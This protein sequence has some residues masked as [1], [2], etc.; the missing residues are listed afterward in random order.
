MAFPFLIL[1]LLFI[2]L[3]FPVVLPLF[4]IEVPELLRIEATSKVLGISRILLLRTL[5]PGALIILLVF[6]AFS[7]G[8]II[9]LLI[10]LSTSESLIEVWVL[11]LRL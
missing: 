10:V 8:P 4:S 3:L 9:V 1:S 5:L 2:L 11:V 7:F 6:I